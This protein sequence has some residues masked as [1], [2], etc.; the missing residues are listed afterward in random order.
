MLKCRSMNVVCRGK[1]SNMFRDN[2]M[3]FVRT[4][5]EICKIIKKLFKGYK[6]SESNC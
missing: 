3:N 2:V 1:Y 5:N 4:S 6:E